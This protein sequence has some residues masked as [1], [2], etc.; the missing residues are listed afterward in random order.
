MLK[1]IV[2][3]HKN[4]FNI[5]WF[6]QKKQKKWLQYWS[7]ILQPMDW[8][9]IFLSAESRR[10][11]E[12]ILCRWI[13]V[14]ALRIAT[15]PSTRSARNP[16]AGRGWGKHN[17]KRKI[18]LWHTS[19]VTHFSHFYFV[20]ST[21]R[22]NSALKPCDDNVTRVSTSTLYA[23]LFIL[24]KI[25]KCTDTL[26]KAPTCEDLFPILNTLLLFISTSELHDLWNTELQFR[27]HMGSRII[28]ILSE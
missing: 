17:V 28:I 5:I 13:R 2:R 21:R 24:N 6:E 11:I 8:I 26:R 22:K 3:I 15:S 25:I 9:E 18:M 7:N 19:F 23:P 16:A 1:Q 27:N 12:A 14:D 4:H 20:L 10:V